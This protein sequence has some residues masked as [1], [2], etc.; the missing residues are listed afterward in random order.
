MATSLEVKLRTAAAADT[1]LT[2]LLGTNPFRWFE[3]QFQ[4]GTIFPEVTVLL[5]D[6]INQYSV[7][8]LLSTAL[9]RV[10]FT[11]WDTDPERARDVETAI[12]DFLVG[13][14]AMNNSSAAPIQANTVISRRQRG[15]AQ[16]EPFTYQR[17]LD[18]KIFNNENL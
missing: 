5:V 10:Q 3:S 12:V 6:T 2:G 13:F 14:N 18:A 1:T 4:Q 7:T 11:V 17:I 9:S 8:N 15:N 16:T